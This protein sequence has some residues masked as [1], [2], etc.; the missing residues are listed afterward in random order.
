MKKVQFTFTLGQIGKC[1]AT[2]SAA[3][4]WKVK[5]GDDKAN[6]AVIDRHIG[7]LYIQM[8]AQKATSIR[9]PAEV[10]EKL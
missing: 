3:G 4:N 5:V 10:L 1:K 8:D 6:H 7:R 2:R 9:I